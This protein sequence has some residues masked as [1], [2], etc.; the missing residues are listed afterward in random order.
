MVLCPGRPVTTPSPHPQS[1]FSP[2]TGSATVPIANG[3]WDGTA[4][5]T[6]R[7][8]AYGDWPRANYLHVGAGVTPGGRYQT[9]LR[10]DTSSSSSSTAYLYTR[11]V[12]SRRARSFHLRMRRPKVFWGTSTP[13]TFQLASCTG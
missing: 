8:T 5:G 7:E 6:A 9:R 13:M 11:A 12:N 10:A 4:I 3:D 1:R 2:D